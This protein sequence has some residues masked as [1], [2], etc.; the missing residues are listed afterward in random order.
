MLSAI[1]EGSI[2]QF[3]KSIWESQ[4]GNIFP[5]AVNAFLL[6]PAKH[7]INFAGLTIYYLL[8]TFAVVMSSIYILKTLFEFKLREIKREYLLTYIATSLVTFEGAFVPSFAGGFSFSLASLAHLWPIILMAISLYLY[9]HHANLAPIAFILGLLIGNS[10]AGESF[11]SLVI[12]TILLINLLQASSRSLRKTAYA[13]CQFLGILIGFIFMV[14]AP[15]F[16]NRAN[17]SVG[18]PSSGS[19]LFHRTLKALVSFSADSLTHPGAYFAFGLGLY[20][21]RMSAIEFDVEVFRRKYKTFLKIYI[22]LLC[23]L[24]GGGSL[25]YSSWHQALGVD[26][27]LTPLFFGGGVILAGKIGNNFLKTSLSIVLIF[28][29]LLT[30]TNIRAGILI[31]HRAIVWDKSFSTNICVLKNGHNQKLSGAELR[32]PP[33]NLGIEDIQSWPWMEQGY[34]KWMVKLS[35]YKTKSCS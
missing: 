12:S 23:S 9:S 4:G 15:G 16:S 25:A 19:E 13:F 2:S 28:S 26:L 7:Q 32:Y 17:N 6:A 10:N 27:L 20:V 3:L 22:L 35:E 21:V 18:F 24:I 14:S 31:N 5:Y 8:T 33:L 1:S 30:S 11:T 34:K 29:I